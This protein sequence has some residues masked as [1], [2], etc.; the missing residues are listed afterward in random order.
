MGIHIG[1][2]LCGVKLQADRNKQG[3]SSNSFMVNARFL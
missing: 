1:D 2:P 3:I